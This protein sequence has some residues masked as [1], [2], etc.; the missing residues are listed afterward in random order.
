MA[1]LL[2]F[3]MSHKPQEFNNII[4][5]LLDIIEKKS[6]SYDDSSYTSKLFHQ[7]TDRVI[8]KFGEEAIEVVIAAGSNKK[9]DLIYETADLIYHLLILLRKKNISIEEIANELGKRKN[10]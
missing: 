7:E 6:S 3:D 1:F 5:Y 4:K 9:K 2:E 10:G 8:Q